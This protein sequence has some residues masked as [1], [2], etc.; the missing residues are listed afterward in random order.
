MIELSE[1]AIFDAV[2]DCQSL[3][4]FKVGIAVD[5]LKTHQSVCNTISS[6][7]G[8]EDNIRIMRPPC[9]LRIRL[10][11]GSELEVFIPSSRVRGRAFHQV[12]CDPGI[13]EEDKSFLMISEKLKHMK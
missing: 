7:I 13:S 3:Q 11:N 8:C 9:E 2:Y 6:I 4:H 10:K 12:I 1:K 5:N